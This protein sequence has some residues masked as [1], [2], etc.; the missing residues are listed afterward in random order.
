M[1]RN[2]QYDKPLTT[3]VPKD[4]IKRIQQYA[5]REQRS[6]S[7]MQKILVVE[8]LDARDKLNGGKGQ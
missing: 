6:M 4:V 2:G 8:A 1:K 7:S 5:K 3:R